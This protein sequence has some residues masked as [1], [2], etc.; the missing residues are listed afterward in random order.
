MVDMC[1]VKEI[2]DNPKLFYVVNGEVAVRLCISVTIC[3]ENT[4]DT[5]IKWDQIVC[6]CRCCCCE[7]TVVSQL[8]VQD[9]E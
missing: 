3:G 5:R 7:D 8:V 2:G 9:A 1:C 6:V 4:A